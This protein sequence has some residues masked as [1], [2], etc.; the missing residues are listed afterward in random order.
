MPSAIF[1]NIDDV[2][3]HLQQKFNDHNKRII[4]IYAFNT[5]GKTRLSRQLEDKPLSELE[6]EVNTELTSLCYSVFIEDLF[7]WENESQF[8]RYKESWI[9]NLLRDEGL[10][11]RVIN[12]FKELSSSMVEPYFD[13]FSCTITFHLPSLN[14]SNIKISK[15]EESIFVWSIFYTILELVKETLEQ[16]KDERSVSIFNSL[17]YIIIDDPVSSIDDT[18][19]IMTAIKTAD[20]IK[21]IIKLDSNIKF[22]ITTHHALF[23]NVLHNAFRGNNR[24]CGFILSKIQDKLELKAQ[25]SDAPFSYHLTLINEIGN[26]IRNGTVKRYHFNMFRSILEKTA[27]FMG[28]AKFSDCIPEQDSK[29]VCIKLLNHYSHSRLSDIEY[30][31]VPEDDIRQLKLL[32]DSFIS[33]YN[34][35]VD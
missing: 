9:F 21:E 30:H 3:Q 24:C 18:R 35:K 27:N 10:E 5:T 19:I 17:N 13:F 12:N 14:I 25:R 33:R 15:G 8:F 23:Y 1:E 31:G 4:L 20:L 34:F 22:L 6:I 28:Y 7:Y 32:F 29:N 2:K 11:P 16:P 26:A